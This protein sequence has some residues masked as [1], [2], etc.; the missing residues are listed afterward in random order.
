MRSQTVPR[1]A[2]AAAALAV[3]AGVVAAPAS[4]VQAGGKD[5]P[6]LVDKAVVPTVRAGVAKWVKTWWTSRSD[7]CDVRVTVT[8]DDVAALTYPSNTGSYTSLS[9]SAN[10]AGGD[11]DYTAFRVTPDA[12]AAGFITLQVSVSY[13]KRPAGTP[14]P[15]SGGDDALCSGHRSHRATTARL[16]VRPR[17]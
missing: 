1:V 17:S 12:D 3:A 9:R 15:G 6:R 13:T 4:A 5:G 8:G 2:A 11:F 10:L 7:V 16:Y 14:S